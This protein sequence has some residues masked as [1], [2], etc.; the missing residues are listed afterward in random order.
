MLKREL[1]DLKKEIR[2]SGV[3]TRGGS[4]G[5]QA[6]AV[7]TYLYRQDVINQAFR[8]SMK[9]G[10]DDEEERV[11]IINSRFNE[12]PSNLLAKQLFEKIPA[13][14]K[15][16]TGEAGIERMKSEILAAPNF[17]LTIAKMADFAFSDGQI[18]AIDMIGATT[19]NKI[20]YG[21]STSSYKKQG[22]TLQN[23]E[24]FA[25]I[26]SLYGTGDPIAVEV[27]KKLVPN[28]FKAYQQALQEAI[29]ND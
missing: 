13:E 24:S 7:K 2:G 20:G 23:A 14:V 5:D 19:K 26:N 12:L 21:H 3:K 10:G 27:L 8:N 16:Q 28:Q 18:P 9:G 17:P 25:N 11:K 4:E 29:G 15:T 6:L 22:V 1:A